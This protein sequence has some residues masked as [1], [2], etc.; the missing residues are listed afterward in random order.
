MMLL[1]SSSTVF[2]QQF[3][4]EGT[5]KDEAGMTLPGASVL[6][7]GTQRGTE[8]NL[9]GFFKLEVSA[10]ETLVVSYVGMKTKELRV[11]NQRRLNVVLEEDAEQL[12]DVVVIGYGSGKKLGSTVGSVARI[13]GGEI[14][15]KPSGNALDAMQGKVAGL[16]IYTSSGEPSQLSSSRLHGVG[17]LGASST[18]LYVV[19][20]IPV[21]ASAMRSLNPADFEDVTVLK[22]ASATSIYGSRAANGVIYI[23]TKKGK[24]NQKTQFMVNSQYGFSNLA[25]RTLFDNM[26]NSDELA[27]FWVETG[28]RT[29][30]QVDDLRAEYP[31]NTRWDKV[32]FKNNVPMAQIDVSASGGSDKMTHHISG[33][34]L[35]QEGLVYRS[36]FERYTL[37][38]NLESKANDWIHMGI[39]L[40]MGY[41]SYEN[42]SF[43]ATNRLDGGLSY[44]A[45]PFYS[46]V[47]KDGNRYDFIPGWDRYHPEYYADKNPSNT[48]RV[49]LL[50]SG[51]ISIMPFKNFIFKTQGGIQ[52]YMSEYS[53][54]RLPSYLN[55][56]GNGEV[57]RENLKY[58]SQTLTNTA[59]Y[60]FELGDKNKFTVLA[61]QETLMLENH[62]IEA[63]SSG[64]FNDNL[65]LL[66]HGPNNRT[67][68]EGR[69]R[70]SV[71]SLFSRIDYS[72][73]EKYFLDVSLRRDGSSRFGRD[74]RYANF[75]SAGVMWNVKKENFMN[76]ISS[77]DRLRLRATTGTSGNSEIGNYTSFSLITTSPYG[78]AMGYLISNAENPNLRWERQHK[79][80]LGFDIEMFKRFSL[81]VDVYHRLT[82]DMLMDVPRAYTSGY[83]YTKENV[84]KLLNRGIDVTFSVEAIKGN[85]FRLEPY[86]NLNYNREKITELF[87]GKSS[88]VIPGTAIGYGVGQPVT[89]Y[90]PVF[91]GVNP[92]TG[93]AE[94]F[95]P[96]S[97]RMQNTQDPAS[98]SS[99][100]N[101]NALEQSTGIRRFAPF[102]SGFGFD[103]RYKS[104]SLQADFSAVLGKH[105][106]NNDRYF[107]EN[108]TRFPGYN[109]SRE[110]MDYW[111]NPGDVTRFPKY[112]Q[113]FTE[114]DSRL[115]EN[116]S[117]MRL[118]NVTLSYTL[119]EDIVKEIGFFSKVRFYATGRNLLTVTKYS[120]LDPEVD[121]NIGLGTNPNTKQIVCGVEI[122]F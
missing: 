107:A 118:K 90:Y 49:E 29:Q 53:Y 114:F 22:D 19:D 46:P 85:D 97:D 109:Q 45:A 82:S 59:E 21:A 14:A 115:V 25:N 96:G 73:D 56:L 2:A 94:W 86:I 36:G 75:W 40:S 72:F 47:D 103:A 26:M 60:K 44:M 79:T 113:N 95:V 89:F 121:S 30:A 43:F 3:T 122:K 23:T 77:I 8:A 10:G 51:Y 38:S 67:V 70:S 120:G 48:S 99:T 31:H 24:N 4:L 98:V 93:L 76:N 64:Q 7:K 112:G 91:S 62:T 88:W 28:Y 80:T 71:N 13:S 17:S 61:G 63:S 66:V 83:D 92:D 102:M 34:F 74:N 39:T 9:D 54:T 84:G 55:S 57:L 35:K 68:G 6:V 100:F 5:V 110:V 78:G 65:I 52:Y 20:G 18:P 42:N 50:P 101:A 116:A 105:L 27:A 37:R 16:Q 33:S 87:Q 117:F 81:T 32:Y 15:E 111:K 11:S 108:P 12:D 119:A 69:T 41:N 58:L 106:I 104:F 1:A